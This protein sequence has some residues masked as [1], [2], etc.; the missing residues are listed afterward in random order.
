MSWN[1][2]LQ[3]LWWQHQNWRY[4]IKV[5]NR[6]DLHIKNSDL[7]ITKANRIND[8]IG[9][10]EEDFYCTLLLLWH[11]SIMNWI[12]V[13][14]NKEILDKNTVYCTDNNFEFHTKPNIARI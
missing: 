5:K 4:F 1:I 13:P 7:S 14:C 2:Y 11:P 9:T 6:Y 10:F 3:Y 12:R 8:L